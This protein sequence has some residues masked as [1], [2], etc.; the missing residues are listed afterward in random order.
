MY[1]GLPAVLVDFRHEAPHTSASGFH[2]IALA[3]CG[4]LSSGCLSSADSAHLRNNAICQLKLLRVWEDVFL[5]QWTSGRLS[6]SLSLVFFSAGFSLS[7][8][9][10]FSSSL[11]SFASLSWLVSGWSVLG[12]LASQG[13]LSALDSY[14]LSVSECRFSVPCLKGW[15]HG[16]WWFVKTK[17][18]WATPKVW[19][20][21]SNQGQLVA[22]LRFLGEP[23][24]IQQEFGT[25]DTTRKHLS[26]SIRG[27]GFLKSKKSS[28]EK[29]F[30]NARSK[31]DSWS[32]SLQKSEIKKKCRDCWLNLSRDF[33]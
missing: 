2:Y 15:A 1:R 6:S 30:Q 9:S 12:I 13:Q 22:G 21:F 27:K 4:C 19:A 7:L 18:N 28:I 8:Q 31:S 23:H 20:C 33:Q 5:G 24:K 29:N 11:Q 17:T 25:T 10:G 16:K 3:A 14:T 32:I 26:Q